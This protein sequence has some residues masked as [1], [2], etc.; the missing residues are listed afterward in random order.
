MRLHLMG[1]SSAVVVAS[2]VSGGLLLTRFWIL[3]RRPL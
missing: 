3:S 1:I 2:F